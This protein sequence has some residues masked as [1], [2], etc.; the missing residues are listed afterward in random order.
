MKHLAL[1]LVLAIGLLVSNFGTA[2]AQVVE[3]RLGF[4]ALAGMIPSL[5]GQ[6][7][8]NE[9]FD[10]VAEQ[11]LQ[12]TTTGL[13]VWRKADNSTSFTNGATTW[14]LGPLGVQRRPNDT[15]FAWERPAAA[16]PLPTIE[17]SSPNI[18]LGV[19]VQQL[20]LSPTGRQLL[21]AGTANRV[22]LTRR[23]LAQGVLGTYIPSPNIAIINA[24]LDPTTS[25]V[26]ATVLAHELQHALDASTQGEP[27][28]EAQCFAFETR[29]FGVQARVWRELWGGTLP[30]ETG[31]FIAEM[32][33][34]ARIVETDP[35]GFA[36]RLARRYQSECGP[37]P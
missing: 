21:A 3:F 34:I 28:T 33:D 18:S 10:P 11:S 17:H 13:M 2:T 36:R 5:V 35:E 7:L 22:L 15:L 29:A 30:P 9:H 31:A 32:N 37:L 26:R 16:I 12:N 24:R 8:E 20:S 19:G 6:P 25:Q 23:F 1:S 4:A 27:A 14:V